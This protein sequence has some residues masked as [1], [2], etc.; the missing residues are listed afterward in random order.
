M[1][2]KYRNCGIIFKFTFRPFVWRF[3]IECIEI[4][5][6]TAAKQ[7]WTALAVYVKIG[8]FEVFASIFWD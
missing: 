6:A 3:N 2:K 4:A 7:R 5:K 1:F 8:P